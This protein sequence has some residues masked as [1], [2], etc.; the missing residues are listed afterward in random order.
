MNTCGPDAGTGEA[1]KI[2]EQ[3]AAK[4][5]AIRQPD[6]ERPPSEAPGWTDREARG[7]GGYG[8][9]A[10]ARKS[11]SSSEPMQLARSHLTCP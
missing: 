7:P 2:A 9:F 10:S 3:I 4:V 6:M 5:R 8:E 11:L 1:G